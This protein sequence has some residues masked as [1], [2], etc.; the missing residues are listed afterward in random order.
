MS[1][2]KPHESR[3]TLAHVVERKGPVDFTTRRLVADLDGLGLRRLVV[4]SNR[5]PALLT[6]KHAVRE[7][8]PTVEIVMEEES[9]VEKHQSNGTIEVTVREIHKQLRLTEILLP[10]W[11]SSWSTRK[12]DIKVS[13]WS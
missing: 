11:R 10:S 5:E 7:T 4:N 9:L 2:V 1:A 8:M 13:S 6:L 3:M 12:T